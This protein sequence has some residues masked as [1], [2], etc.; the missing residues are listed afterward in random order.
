MQ[1]LGPA[2]PGAER[3]DCSGCLVIPGNVCTHTHLYSALARGMPYSLEPP[4]T[5]VQIL[6]RVW[7]RLDRALDEEGIRASAL[8]GG[9]EALL[10]GTT[11]LVDHHASPNA[12]DGSLDVIADALDEVGI[13]SVLCYETTDR[14]GSEAAAA[15]VAE[16]RRFIS[17]APS[18]PRTRGMV[19]A[20]ASFTLSAETLEAC[21]DLSRTTGAGIHVHVAED[22]SD[23][24]DSEARFGSSVA[25]RLA[26]SG[27]LTSG[28]LLA[29]C[30]YLSPEEIRVVVD[31]GA[32]VAH[33]ARSNMNNSVG[34][35]L[36]EAL[37]DRVALGTDG[38]GADMFAESQTAHWRAREAAV[39]AQP[40][41]TLGRLANGSRFVGTVFGEPSLGLVEPG[42]PADLAVLDYAAPAPIAETTLGQHWMFAMSAR[43]VRDVIVD[44]EVVV[45]D[46]RVT[47]VD[48]DKLF[49]DASA[50]AE[51]VF[52]RLETIEAHPF[53]P[54]GAS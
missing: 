35:A 43:H 25:L 11:T 37:G 9:I 36:V 54:V 6:Q 49:A 41:E 40:T 23:Q 24:V 4:A 26:E 8:V 51:R 52:A 32:T 38:I 29:H 12:I 42:A 31:S 7:W 33:N 34:R 46:R 39:F 20:H 10:A 44:G 50:A 16:N 17:L 5:F 2:A 22:F 19:G 28:A 13:R 45:R 21:V 30:V 1:A 14:D 15:G 53:D 48:Q 27:A 3:L 18:R 47:N